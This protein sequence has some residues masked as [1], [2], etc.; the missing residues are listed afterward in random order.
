[1]K[2]ITQEAE[3][4]TN[5]GHGFIAFICN[6]IDILLSKTSHLSFRETEDEDTVKVDREGQF[7]AYVHN[8]VYILV[9]WIQHISKRDITEEKRHLMFFLHDMEHHF[10]DPH[11]EKR[12]RDAFRWIKVYIKIYPGVCKRD[13]KEKAYE[14]IRRIYE[15][16]GVEWRL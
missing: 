8:R 9:M 15:A 13:R 11:A 1:M 6:K 3:L 14:L 10:V 2:T 7:A 4:K 5:S 12:L 16:I